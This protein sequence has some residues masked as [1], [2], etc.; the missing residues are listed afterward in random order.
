MTTATTLGGRG[1]LGRAIGREV[2][3]AA[4]AAVDS[5]DG[6]YHAFLRLL[7]DEARAEAD[8]VD[9]AVAAGRDRARWR[10]CRWRSRTTCARGER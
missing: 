8:A 4:L 5:G 2:V 6:A 1:A 7:A 3:D 10:E 9:A